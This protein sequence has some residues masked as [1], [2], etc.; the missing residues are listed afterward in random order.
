MWRRKKLLPSE[1]CLVDCD[2]SGMLRGRTRD[3]LRWISRN[4][5]PALNTCHYGDY[6]LPA[7][8]GGF[9]QL[10]WLRHAGKLQ[11]AGTACPQ[12]AS[13]PAVLEGILGV[14]ISWSLSQKQEHGPYTAGA[15]TVLLLDCLREAGSR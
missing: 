13:C 1:L 11:E 8:S 6:L 2:R 15:S 3:R 12:H 10:I 5:V 7:F 4:Y 9:R 14:P